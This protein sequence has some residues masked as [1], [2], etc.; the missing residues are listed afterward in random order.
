MLAV[1]RFGFKYVQNTNSKKE[2]LAG[3]T[4]GKILKIRTMILKSFDDCV[5]VAE[6]AANEARRYLIVSK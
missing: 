4:R 3:F 6:V 2:T 1:S 5:S